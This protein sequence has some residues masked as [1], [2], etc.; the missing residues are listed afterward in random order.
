MEVQE[1]P[2]DK[3]IRQLK[4]EN[5][6]LRKMM[7]AMGGDG[8]D[9][10]AMGGGDDASRGTITED[11]MAAAIEEAVAQVK[12]TSAA[13][14]A[15]A[16]EAVKAEMRARSDG[17]S[18]GMLARA[19]MDQTIRDAIEAA[20]KSPK[21]KEK[22]LV[23]YLKEINPQTKKRQ[24]GGED[25]TFSKGDVAA[26]A[27][28]V[29]RAMG[30]TDEEV[31]RYVAAAEL[32]FDQLLQDGSDGIV[33][34]GVMRATVERALAALGGN[35]KDKQV[36][37]MVQVALKL[38][39]Y[40]GRQ[41]L[42]AAD[43]QQRAKMQLA[44]ALQKNQEMMN[45]LTMSFDAKLS[46]A[47]AE[48]VALLK[49]LGLSGLSPEEMKVTPS[50]RN[51]NQDPTMADALVYY[52]KA[53][54]TLITTPED[55]DGA[56][57]QAIVLSG[58]GLMAKHGTVRYAREHA[59]PIRFVVGN[60]VT[61]VNGKPVDGGEIALRHDDRL[62]L[63]NTQAFRVVDP[64]DPEASKPH[65]QLIDWD[66]AQTELAEA[67]GTAVDLKVEEEVAKKKAELD[68]QFKAM[69]DK[70]ARENE[71]LRAQ[72]ERGGG[73]ASASQAVTLKQLDSRKAAI[74]SHKAR[75]RIHLAEL[76]RELIRLEDSLRKVTPLLKEAN[77]LAS[78]LGRGVKFEAMLVTFIPQ[79]MALSPVEELLTQ[80]VTELLVNVVLSNPR[81]NESREWLWAPEP[82]FDR[83]GHM[84]TAWQ[85]WMLKSIEVPMHV[86]SDPFWSP[87]QSQ[88]IGTA[89]LY[90]API[91]YGV[92]MSEWVPIVDYRSEKHGELC[93]QLKPRARPTNDPDT[94][95]GKDVR[96]D[97]TI[98]AARGLLGCPS[99]N[100]RVE[101]SWANEEVKR[102]ST[103]ADGGKKFEP[104]FGDTHE[105]AIERVGEVQIAYL[106][107]DAICF[108][109]YG[110]PEDVAEEG[111]REAIEMEVPPEVFD[112]FLSY[113]V[114][115]ADG[116]QQ[117]AFE[118]DGKGAAVF[119]VAQ[120][121][122]HRFAFAVAQENRNF[123]V[124]N[125]GNVHL[126]HVREHGSSASID[127]TWAALPIT[128]QSRSDADMTPWVA[129]CMLNF[130]PPSLQGPECV[131]KVYDL[132]LKADVEEIERIGQLEEPI[133]LRKTITLRVVAQGDGTSAAVSNDELKTR[134]R[135][136]TSKQEVY[137]GTFEVTDNA[138]NEAMTA[139]RKST[140]EADTNHAS[141]ILQKYYS[142]VESRKVGLIEEQERQFEALALRAIP[143]GLDLGQSL[144]LWQLP[145][146]LLGTAAA[147]PDDPAA[148]KKLVAELRA[149]LSSSNDQ[150]M[151]AQKKIVQLEAQL[152]EA[153]RKGMK[154]GASMK[155][156]S[157]KKYIVASEPPPPPPRLESA[158]SAK[159][160]AKSS[161]CVI[162]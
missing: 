99:K 142:E 9:P 62:I 54:E 33:D 5:D 78:H 83:V 45:D 29:L 75:T 162:S 16:I 73:G 6:K 149:D 24:A 61:F 119:T 136:T 55:A 157:S 155:A 91:A 118:S 18:Q 86:P 17:L 44:A 26:W 57:A 132:D 67:M 122:G 39:G 70:F 152:E 97:L 161:A 103:A 15:A 130:L 124:V 42:A 85:E 72:L 38:A 49:S 43:A 146:E 77:V 56:D 88:L 126:G 111:V 27:E 131:G 144:E 4:Q 93:I 151:R 35:P 28:K 138:V 63:G 66:L 84:R 50:L 60:G 148:L 159:G 40:T 109:V 125:M 133:E 107:K 101:F 106:C 127:N 46:Q 31:Q 110:E 79:S 158:G 23:A 113:D 1:N 121:T 20:G 47:D 102:K 139:L 68:A 41:S 87:P 145:K 98:E 104:R 140:M 147:V 96:F 92:P 22:A 80:K 89:Y 160:E 94:L 48:S 64:L 10:A 154:R 129:E 69:E 134:L 114:Q 36:A 74:E 19:D 8:F 30:C 21:D 135:L 37:E 123:R 120:G 14:K 153:Q 7:E 53:G 128:K 137:L 82:F 90:L 141:N 108:E 11:Q 12:K 25:D 156:Q 76:K 115:L 150:L 13:E 32:R 65:K 34:E 51:L 71:A 3:L 105:L 58:G 112:A 116:S 81:T 52:L 59:T 95:L 143:L 2:T 117:V 100:V